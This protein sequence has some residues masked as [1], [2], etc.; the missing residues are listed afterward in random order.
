MSVY[1]TVRT[2]KERNAIRSMAVSP[3]GKL[4]AF[5]SSD[6][7][8]V[9]LRER[10]SPDRH[11]VLRGHN[12]RVL[13][14]L[15]SPCGDY[16]YSSEYSGIVIVW[17]VSTGE[18]VRSLKLGSKIY[19]PLAISHSG[20]YLFSIGWG[21]CI[22]KWCVLSG[23]RVLKM[24]AGSSG[25][26]A[27]SLCDGFVMCG[28]FDKTVRIWKADT[29]VC[30]RALEGHSDYVKKVVLIPSGELLA[31]CAGKRDCTIRLWK[32][33]TGEAVGVLQKGDE[34]R[35]LA[36]SP[37]GKYMLAGYQRAG[38]IYQDSTIGLW[39]EVTQ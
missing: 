9:H 15:F 39:D 29:G 33:R 17:K 19:C 10:K 2:C 27:V 26:M 8:T 23:K 21:S 14:V 5:G 31:S 37:G 12:D 22:M 36:V 7:T 4:W 34:V 6:A 28:C 30:E 25:S 1:K 16:L 35:C 38:R 20:R 11:R 32:W 24:R 13:G 3:N 18:Q